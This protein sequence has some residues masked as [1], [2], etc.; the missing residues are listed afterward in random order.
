MEGRNPAPPKKP[1]ND[2]SPVNTNNQWFPMVSKWCRISSIHSRRSLSCSFNC[3]PNRICD[4]HGGEL[5]PGLP[6]PPLFGISPSQIRAGL[7]MEISFKIYMTPPPQQQQQ[8]REKKKQ[9][10]KKKR[11]QVLLGDSCGFDVHEYISRSKYERVCGLSAA[12]HMFP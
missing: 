9:K 1:W 7:G 2:D 11:K 10:N 3:S 4:F 8:K 6:P 12:R 5:G